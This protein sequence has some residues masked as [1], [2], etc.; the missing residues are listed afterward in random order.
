VKQLAFDGS[1]FLIDDETA[2]LL[3]DYAAVLVQHN[4]GDAVDVHAL[5]LNGDDVDVK[6][7]IS[8]GVPLMAESS[9]IDLP[10]PENIEAIAY[11]TAAIDRLTHRPVAVATDEPVQ[12]GFDPYDL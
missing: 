10:V 9:K 1:S 12:S 4:T 2:N 11:M 6:F 3:M 5:S 8:T 7:V